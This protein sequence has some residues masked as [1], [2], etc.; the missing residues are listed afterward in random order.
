MKR[1]VITAMVVTALALACGS[2]T[3]AEDNVTYTVE[4]FSQAATVPPPPGSLPAMKESEETVLT[5]EDLTVTPQADSFLGFMRYMI[6]D[7]PE[8]ASGQ[9]ITKKVVETSSPTSTSVPV[10]KTSPKNAVPDEPVEMSHQELSTSP[11]KG[12]IL[13]ITSS[14]DNALEILM[15]PQGATSASAVAKRAP[16]KASSAHPEGED[17]AHM[18]L[19]RDVQDKGVLSLYTTRTDMAD[20]PSPQGTP[21]DEPKKTGATLAALTTDEELAHQ[22]MASTLKPTDMYYTVSAGAMIPLVDHT[23]R[24]FVDYGGMV[25]AGIHKRMDDRLTLSATFGVGL[26]TGDWSVGGSRQSLSIAAEEYYPGYIKE[27]G[28]TITAEDL[29]ESNLGT[30]YHSEA[31]ATVTNAESLKSIDVHTDLYL[32]PVSLNALYQVKQSSTFNAYVTGGLGFCTAVRDCNSKALKEK[33]FSGPD[34]RAR[35]NDSQSVTGLLVNL[36]GGMRFPVYERL[37]FVCEASATLYDIKAF[38]PVL[39]ISFTKPNPNW[40][41]GSDLSQ[42]S[43]ENPKHIGVFKE[44]YVAN[45]TAGFVIPF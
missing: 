31:E 38:D 37:T 3:R 22:T 15:T 34:Y 43:Y 36:G 25:K 20:A 24:E 39:E 26:L 32:F 13:G 19:T 5:Y 10:A 1:T 7:K 2:A 23:F 41:P 12:G 45:V 29:P 30:S 4:E 9:V 28:T 33:Y 8:E 40:Y 14:S 11:Q 6:S 21:G 44:A 18:D 27:P 35:L 42:W 16:S 17:L